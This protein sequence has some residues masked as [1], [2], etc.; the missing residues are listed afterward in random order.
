MYGVCIFMYTC[1]RC[2]QFSLPGD[3]RLNN[4]LSNISVDVGLEIDNSQRADDK[5]PSVV[6][7]SNSVFTIHKKILNIILE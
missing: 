7:L 2:T 1:R 5:L 6:E 4:N 3:F